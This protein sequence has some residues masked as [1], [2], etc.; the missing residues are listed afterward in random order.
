M[1]IIYMLI[2]MLIGALLVLV[3][4]FLAIWYQAK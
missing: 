3:G 1:P 4:G 2:G